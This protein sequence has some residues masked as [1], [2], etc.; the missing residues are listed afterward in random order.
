M[1]IPQEFPPPPPLRDL[2]ALTSDQIEIG[3]ELPF[4]VYSK[5]RTLLLN[6]GFVVASERQR[7]TLI[8]AGLLVEE[9]R[10]RHHHDV[11]PQVFQKTGRASQEERARMS[12]HESALPLVVG[13]LAILKVAGLEQLNCRVVGWAQGQ[14]LVVSA[15]LL[16]SGMIA[17]VKVGQPI[18]L[19]LSNEKT[20]SKSTTEIAVVRLTDAPYLV[21]KWPAKIE[22]KTVRGSAR[23]PTSLVGLLKWEGGEM[24]GALRDIGES[25]VRFEGKHP[26]SSGIPGI[27]ETRVKVGSDTAYI[28]LKCEILSTSQVS[29]GMYQVGL[30]VPEEHTT[31]YV[32]WRAFVLQTRYERASQPRSR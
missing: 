28:R 14:M 17:P 5:D 29:S 7:D 21:L 19:L 30:A 13:S 12:Q 24:P 6:K 8:E 32:A 3:K 2:V 18:V 9:K 25:G 31:E 16:S 20:V 26:V 23:V 1:V 10:H 4:A 11:G 22:L 27:F 15:P